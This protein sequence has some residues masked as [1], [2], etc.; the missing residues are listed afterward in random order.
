VTEPAL[1]LATVSSGYGEAI[2]VRDVDLRVG[3]GEIMAL[4]GKNG[5]GKTTLLKAVMGFLPKATGAVVVEGADVTT[6]APHRIAR[7][8]VAYIAQEKSLFQDLTVEQNLRLALVAGQS[9]D[10]VTDRVRAT[11]PFLLE[12]LAQRAGT[13]SGGE[14]KMLLMSR[15][16]ATGARLVLVDEITEGLQP[17]VIER[18]AGV[19]QVER[20]ANG[21][22]FLL[23]EQN[24]RFSLAVAD[25]YAVLDIGEIAEA[26][27]TGSLGAAASITA[28][29][30]V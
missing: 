24:V 11:F 6:W 12:R 10:E 19:I 13:L 8:G 1:D 27:A 30:S 29:L 14:Q 15:A 23:V 5:M 21:T 7:R 26:G 9:W 18:L 20:D 28:R 17:S 16:L 3:S 2:V 4:L 22:A 25:R